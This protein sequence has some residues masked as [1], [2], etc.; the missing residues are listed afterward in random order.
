MS[1]RGQIIS[2]SRQVTAFRRTPVAHASL[3]SRG[4]A[5]SLMGVFALL[6]ET[7]LAMRAFAAFRAPHN[8]AR[9]SS[10]HQKQRQRRSRP[11]CQAT[12]PGQLPK[13]ASSSGFTRRRAAL[14]NAGASQRKRAALGRG[15]ARSN[16]LRCSAAAWRRR[17]RDDWSQL[18]SLG[19]FGACLAAARR[20]LLG[21]AAIF[22]RPAAAQ[23][24]GRAPAP[25]RRRSV[26]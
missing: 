4:D 10:R 19:A 7:R 17:D 24:Q 21:P 14:I 1:T 11:S 5:E 6:P 8:A 18:C 25:C 12:D 2:A 20:P 26:L 15:A 23:N 22:T 13:C 16:R 9:S 3:A